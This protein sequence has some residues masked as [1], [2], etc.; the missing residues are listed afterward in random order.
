MFMVPGK[1]VSIF[2]RGCLA[3]ACLGIGAGC[4]SVKVLHR[5]PVLKAAQ[6]VDGGIGIAAVG[7]MGGGEYFLSQNVSDAVRERLAVARPGI[8]F[9]GLAEV[10]SL[11]PEDGYRSFI[12]EFSE[13][14]SVRP[15]DWK[16]LERLSS[17]MRYVMLVGIATEDIRESEGQLEETSES[18]VQN[19]K[20][21][22]W[23]TETVTDSY[24]K[25]RTKKRS[26]TL[27]FF[28]YDLRTR[29]PV[30]IAAGSDASEAGNYSESFSPAFDA[31]S[32]P[33]APSSMEPIEAIVKRAVGKLPR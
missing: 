21:G 10:K 15:Q 7:G 19:S 30:W 29:R 4:A 3:I 6:L 33:S 12:Q 26:V 27:H 1:I 17:K 8:P 14:S 16:L 2:A 5:D 11:L 20:T 22:K 32:W 18:Y 13:V 25:T 23:E 24:V 9:V 31:P 28:I